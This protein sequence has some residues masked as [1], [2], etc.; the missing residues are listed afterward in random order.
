MILNFLLVAAGFILLI[1]GADW[2]VEGA[3]KLAKKHRI[4]DLVIGLTI[5]ALGTSMPELVVNLIASVENHSDIV[6]GNILG[7]NIFNTFVILGITAMVFPI[8]ITSNLVKKEIPLSIVFT[9]LVMIFS[10]PILGQ[11]R[12]ELNRWEGIVMLVLFVAFIYFALQQPDENISIDEKHSHQEYSNIKIWSFI[13]IGLILLVVGGKFVVDNAINIAQ[14][15]GVSEKIIAL[16]IV[17]AGTSLP[18]L[19][20]SVVAASKKNSDIAIGNVVG[21]GIFNIIFVLSAS[22]IIRPLS[23]NTKFNIELLLIIFGTIL[24]IIFMF[25]YKRYKIDRREGAL[26][27]LLFLLYSA[28]LIRD[29]I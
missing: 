11:S 7:S 10:N 12:P 6:Y 22:A 23:F 25:T 28:Y 29:E 15:F 9:M 1:K 2:L 20:T 16:T 13:I 4:P 27:F 26:L 24:V 8:T 14:Y 17:A 19:V 3:S 5:V 18:E 21:S